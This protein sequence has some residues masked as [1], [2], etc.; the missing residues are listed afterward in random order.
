MQIFMRS[1]NG[2]N[3]K[4]AKMP[5][6]NYS[7]LIKLNKKLKISK[8]IARATVLDSFVE[9]NSGKNLDSIQISS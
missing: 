9:V 3:L 8:R 6:K 5:H 4:N 7:A 2:N 1:S